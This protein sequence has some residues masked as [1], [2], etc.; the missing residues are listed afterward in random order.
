MTNNE[1]QD[2][3]TGFL[4]K[5]TYIGGS[6][7]IASLVAYKESISV[8]LSLSALL[9]T[10]LTFFTNLYFQKKRD[11]REQELAEQNSILFEQGQEDRRKHLKQDTG[12][13]RR[14]TDFN[15]GED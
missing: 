12:D 2:F 14:V 3:I 13:H 9:F 5:I 7:S 6:Y 10:A 1:L 15:L 11:A 4:Q 8:I